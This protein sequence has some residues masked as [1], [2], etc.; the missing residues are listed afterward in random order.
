MKAAAFD[1]V[2][3][4][5]APAELSPDPPVDPPLDVD[6]LHA[7]VSTAVAAMAHA[8]ACLAPI[9]VLKWSRS[10][11]GSPSRDRSMA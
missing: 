2:A 5:S 11:M 10:R 9:G 8:S 3:E 1:T 7:A 6:E 4:A